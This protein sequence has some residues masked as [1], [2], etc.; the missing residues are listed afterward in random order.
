MAK[1]HSAYV[2]HERVQ[3]V[4]DTPSLTRTEFA[5]ECDINAIM[6]RYEKT[7]VMPGQALPNREP[8]YMDLS[9]VPDYQ[10]ALQHVMAA[11][12]AFMQLPAKARAEFDNNPAAFCEFAA[13]PA[14]LDRMREWGL[15]PP[16]PVEPEPVKVRVENPPPPAEKP[17]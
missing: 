4:D 13:D 16:A 3:Y 2:P 11:Q 12:D 9:D 6:A 15:A 10:T 5:Q 17:A 8:V 1:M 14:N 7:G